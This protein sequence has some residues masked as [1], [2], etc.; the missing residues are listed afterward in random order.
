MTIVLVSD[1]NTGKQLK[2]SDITETEMQRLRAAH[3]KALK[4]N[5]TWHFFGG[6]IDIDNKRIQVCG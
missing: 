4:S 5:P 2:Q 1:I 6:T 3:E